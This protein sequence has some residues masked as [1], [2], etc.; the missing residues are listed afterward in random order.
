MFYPLVNGRRVKVI[1]DDLIYFLNAQVL[2][3]FAMD[4]GAKAGESGFY[5]HTKGFTF[6]DVYKFAGMLHFVFGFVVTVQSHEDRPV[7]YIPSKDLPKF[8]A[9]VS[10]HFHHSMM[11]KLTP[12]IKLKEE[13]EQV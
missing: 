11:Y 5:L 4:D 3:I 2:A 1:P 9:L 6:P 8:K 13:K 7:I 10:P 12:K